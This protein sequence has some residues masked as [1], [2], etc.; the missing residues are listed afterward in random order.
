MG[1]HSKRTNHK[2]F[3]PKYRVGQSNLLISI[4]CPEATV[5]PRRV[6]VSTFEGAGR[7]VVAPLSLV[8]IMEWTKVESAFTVE[9]YFSNGRLI[10]ATQRSF[11]T[12][13]NIAPL[14]RVPGRQSIVS[15]VNN[16][17]E[18]GD[19][20]KRKPGLPRAVRSPQN[21][22]MVRLSVV[23]PP[24]RSVRKHAAA[25][26]LSARSVRRILFEELK[27]NPYK[28][29]ATLPRTPHLLEGRSALACTVA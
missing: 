6:G 2:I 20:K 1:Q 19:V 3:L 27:F 9:A 4:W 26:G 25:L 7:K 22:D 5:A 16:I 21:T 28:L 10:I 29:A 14:G 23:R 17:R 18:T 15:W 11:R 12:H 13:F 24:Q 8:S